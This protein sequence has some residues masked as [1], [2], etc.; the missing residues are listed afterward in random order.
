MIRDVVYVSG[1][2]FTARDEAHHRAIEWVNKGTQIPMNFSGL[3]MYHCGPI[4]RKDNG[5][6]Q[7]VSAGPTTSN[8]MEMYESD[9]IK[10]FNI[11]MIIGKG[12]MGRKTTEAMMEHGAVYVAFPGG[13]GALAAQSIIEVKNVF[14]LDLGMPEALWIFR[15]RCF[16]PLIVAI[17]SLGNN[18]YEILFD[19]FE[20]NITRLDRE[21]YV[22][23]TDL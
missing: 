16:G 22:Y 17:D 5:E 12:G 9:F 10:K 3:P 20:E 11:P 8:R 2:I 6:W 4:A 15:T 7:I 18:L 1:E 14:W 19:Q 23:R 13:A 21:N